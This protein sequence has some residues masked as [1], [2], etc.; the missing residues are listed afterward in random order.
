MS[1]TRRFI[2]S[3]ISALY[4]LFLSRRRRDSRGLTCFPLLISPDEK[5]AWRSN[6][7]RRVG[8]EQGGRESVSDTQIGMVMEILEQV[9][10]LG[11]TGV[12]VALGLPVS[13]DDII[14]SAKI[15]QNVPGTSELRN[16]METCETCP[17]GI[18][19]KLNI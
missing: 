3:S 1:R 9:L 13:T 7:A 6:G 12:V 17:M 4:R 2:T 5:G 16:A 8:I 10:G 15:R 19:H 18:C 11:R 14:H